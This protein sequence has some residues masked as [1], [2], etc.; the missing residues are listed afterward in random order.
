M[1]KPEAAQLQ[2]LEGTS[3]PSAQKDEA[4]K[5][6]ESQKKAVPAKKFTPAK[7]KSPA[8]ERKASQNGDAA[9]AATPT[10]LAAAVQETLLEQP[11]T[12]QG[13]TM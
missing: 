6:A 1:C 12:S 3:K 11:S 2:V 8:K 5:E 7:R 9:P 10:E 13:H 4:A